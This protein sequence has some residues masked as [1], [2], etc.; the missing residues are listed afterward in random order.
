MKEIKLLYLVCSVNILTL[1]SKTYLPFS[2]RV[3][4]FLTKV[5]GKG[6]GFHFRLCGKGQGVAVVIADTLYI[7]ILSH[8]T[9]L[10]SPHEAFRFP[11]RG[12]RPVKLY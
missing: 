10:V 9:Q 6:F 2:G 4:T 8:R 3:Y 5:L 11:M 12:Q 1:V 7:P